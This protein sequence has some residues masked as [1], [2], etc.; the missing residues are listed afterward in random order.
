M[1]SRLLKTS[2]DE[3]YRI[4]LELGIPRSILDHYVNILVDL[5]VNDQYERYITTS[6]TIINQLAMKAA[7]INYKELTSICLEG[8]LRDPDI[9]YYRSILYRVLSIP[10]LASLIPEVGSNLAYAP[11][12]PRS[13]SDIIGLTG[14]I[15]KSGGGVSFYGFP[16][17]GG[18]RHVGRILL[19]VSKYKSNTKFCINI[20]YDR[21][22]LGKLESLGLKLVKT[23]PHQNEDEYW[24]AIENSSVENQM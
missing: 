11:R 14:R 6:F 17:Y 10:N 3:Y 7:C 24:T 15:V 13:L 1:I 19:L 12:P 23:G 18:S 22:I 9:E 4:L 5:I 2:I 21:R 20:K 8:D 16:M